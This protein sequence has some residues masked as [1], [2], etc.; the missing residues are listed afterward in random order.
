VKEQSQIEDMRAAVRGDRERAEQA[1]QHLFEN[2]G[3]VTEAPLAAHPV[4]QP[5]RAAERRR[6][7]G[8]FK[9]R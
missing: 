6:L 4:D 1:R 8:L 3:T 2:L 5:A 9:R 7:R